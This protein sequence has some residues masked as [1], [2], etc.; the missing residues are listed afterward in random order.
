MTWATALSIALASACVVVGVL[1]LA[2]SRAPGWTVTR[3]FGVASLLGGLFTASNVVASLADVPGPVVVLGSQLGGAFAA[4][5]VAAWIVYARA[6]AAR[7]LTVFDRGSMVAAVLV[8]ALFLVPDLVYTTRIIVLPVRWWGVSYRFPETT[9]LALPVYAVLLAVLTHAVTGLW[10]VSRQSGSGGRI[11]RGGL[12]LF[13]VTALNEALVAA[14]LVT[15]PFLLEVGFAA[16]IVGVGIELTT[17]VLSD[18]RALRQLSETLD[19]QVTE[20]TAELAKA[21]TELARAERL[22]ALGH[23]A[24]AVGHEI[25][26][27]LTYVKLNLAELHE[28]VRDDAEAAPIA[29][30]ALDG[31]DRIQR[32]VADLQVLGVPEASDDPVTD[33]SE[34][35]EDALV[36]VQPEVTGAVQLQA[37][38]G[39]LPRVRGNAQQLT[40]VFVHL[41]SN[42]VEA[43]WPDGRPLDVHIEVSQQGPWVRV[44]VV[45]DGV[46][47]PPELQQRVAEPFFSTKELHDRSGTGLGLA[48]ARAI[49]LSCGGRLTILSDGRTGSRV[50]VVLHAADVATDRP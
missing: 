5:H 37:Q 11:L 19:A 28:A 36:Q 8:A 14:H 31:V 12:A 25:N 6:R 48:L 23:L 10:R 41:L 16:V 15:A 26:N 22:A 35:L 32:V 43:T 21:Q 13:L 50:E 39:D 24:G 1:C 18:A 29:A 4:L 27:P 42:A 44:S 3:W 20:R 30:E 17:K 2:V 7:R 40:Q 9:V 49:V 47:I 38:T 45:D 33:L 34:V 46:G